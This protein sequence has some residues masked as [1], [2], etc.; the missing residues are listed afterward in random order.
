MLIYSPLRPTWENYSVI[1]NVRTAE[2]SRDLDLVKTT[3]DS[4]EEKPRSYRGPAN[5]LFSPQKSQNMKGMQKP[6][7]T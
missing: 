2:G 6:Y 4:Q 5:P 1:N 3:Y 7:K